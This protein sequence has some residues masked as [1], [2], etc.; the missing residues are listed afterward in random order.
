M[1]HVFPEIKEDLFAHFSKQFPESKTF[2]ITNFKQILGGADTKIFGFDLMINNFDDHIIPLVVRIFERFSGSN[3]EQVEFAILE[4]LYQNKISVPKP[5]FYASNKFHYLVMERIIGEDLEDRI[6]RSNQEEVETL[7]FK[8][9]SEM[10][11]I[12]QLPVSAFNFPGSKVDQDPFVCIKRDLEYPKSL[13]AKYHLD[14]LNPLIQW[15]EEQM[16]YVPCNQMVLTHGDYHIKNVLINQDDQLFI[17][18]WSNIGYHDRRHDL[19][20]S[21]VTSNSFG[22]IDV[23]PIFLQLYETISGLRI[24]NIE[25]FMILSSI[26][27]LLRIY[28]FIVNPEITQED[29]VTTKAMIKLF[30]PYIFYLNHIINEV[31]G[32][33]LF[34]IDT[35]INNYKEGA[36]K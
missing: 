17:I 8:F 36:N 13:I 29:P 26:H 5:Y 9:I 27:N 24:E 10:V 11:R 3:R 31:T 20:F 2:N 32:I 25:Y 15:L 1:E 4:K 14:E 7:L 16:V 30:L 35:F 12:H 19:A 33:S 22:S 34:T 6:N 23:K 18:D 28:S 21:I